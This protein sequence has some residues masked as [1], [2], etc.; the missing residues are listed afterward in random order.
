MRQTIYEIVTKAKELKRAEAIEWLKKNDSVPLRRVLRWIYDPNLV[1]LLPNTSPPWKQNDGVGYEHMLF[2]ES[3]RL[4][5]FV[6]DG[7][8]PNLDKIK[9]EN[10]F[11]AILEGVHNDDANLLCM[12][13]TRT[14]PK[15]ITEKLVLEAFPDLYSTSFV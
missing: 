5:I 10:L 12:G 13:L 1:R 11:I 7:G 9:R 15:G 6:E 14:H 4:R 3:R 2:N 8:Y